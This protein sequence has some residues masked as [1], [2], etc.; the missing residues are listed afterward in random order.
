MHDYTE[1]ADAL[2][3][4]DK[5]K[6]IGLVQEALNQH[7]NPEDILNKGLLK[8]IGV[9]GDKMENEEMFIPEVLQAAAAMRACI[10]ILRPH[11]GSMDKLNRGTI[12][13]G[14][15]KGDL[16]D[17][18]KNLVAMLLESNGYSVYN[19]GIDISAEQFLT[20]VKEN[21]A[22]VLCLSALLTTT[23][24]MMKKV[25]DAVKEN[26]L[27]D[28]VKIL[29]GGAPLNQNY[30]EQIGADGYGPDAASA[31]RLVRSF[32]QKAI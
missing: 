10:D 18:G 11:L 6:V 21:S 22:E 19:L 29:V 26:G 24:P 4:L 23:M 30:A 20:A 9:V 28:R 16:H 25:V 15:V 32:F 2:V 17:I 12:V 27:R 5:H 8:G 3:R 31:V 13:I 1:I 14:T 7:A